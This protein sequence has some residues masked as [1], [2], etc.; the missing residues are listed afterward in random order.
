MNIELNTLGQGNLLPVHAD[1]L[2]Q[3]RGIFCVEGYEEAVE[4]FFG[5]FE[6]LDFRVSFLLVRKFTASISW[7]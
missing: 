5:G 6:N 7:G 4:T 2:P 1:G 3:R